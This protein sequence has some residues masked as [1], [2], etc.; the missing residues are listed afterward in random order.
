M[1]I[2]HFVNAVGRARRRLGLSSRG[3][4][5]A[6]LGVAALAGSLAVFGGATE[7][8]TQ[9]NGL[10]TH[11]AARLHLFTMHRSDLVVRASKLL[12]GIGDPPVLAV[13]ALLAG[14]LFWR[15]G[16]RLV[17]AL[18]P[19]I[20][21]AVS[22]VSVALTKAIVGRARPPVSLHLVP[23]SDASFP[24]GHATDSAAVCIA[25]ALVLA[26]FILRRPI[27]R[28][29]SVAAGA[30]L[31]GAIGTSRLILGVHWPSDVL[32]GLALGVGVSLAVTISASVFARL[33][34]PP[35]EPTSERRRSV[36]RLTRLLTLRRRAHQQDLGMAA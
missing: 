27:A 7:D 33:T 6:A 21:L 2:G 36:A 25:I 20:A 18:A 35:I 17:V 16:L 5:V 23:E 22:G 13:L 1:R 32:A 14:F 29:A 19:S 26:V 11:D 30:S 24:S 34:P 31:A 3:L 4:L 9:H 8:V 12:S 15:R 10:A 28:L